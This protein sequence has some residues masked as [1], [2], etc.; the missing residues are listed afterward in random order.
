MIFAVNV[1]NSVDSDKTCHMLTV[2]LPGNASPKV[3]GDLLL[4]NKNINKK[5]KNKNKNDNYY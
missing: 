3:I 5:N 4:K 2:E 1:G